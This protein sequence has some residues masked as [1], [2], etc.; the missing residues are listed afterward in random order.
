[1]DVDGE[2]TTEREYA[3]MAEGLGKKLKN[4][5]SGGKGTL[6]KILKVRAFA[7]SWASSRLRFPS[8]ARTTTEFEPPLLARRRTSPTRSARSDRAKTAAKS[9]TCPISSRLRVC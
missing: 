4:A 7:T 6:L 8:L 1:M 5:L 2:E 9:R 3:A